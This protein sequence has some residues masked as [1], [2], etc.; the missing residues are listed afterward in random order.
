M[1]CIVHWV[2]K[3]WT[4]LSDFHSLQLLRE[5]DRDGWMVFGF[6]DLD[7][8]NVCYITGFLFTLSHLI[9]K[10]SLETD[11]TFSHFAA[12]NLKLIELPTQSDTASM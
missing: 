11:T 12:E 1:D 5:T 8:L 3:S 9:S 2:A 10:T 6:R 7:V 4:R